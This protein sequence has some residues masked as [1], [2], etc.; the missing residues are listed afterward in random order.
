M[1]KR[2]IAVLLILCLCFLVIAGDRGKIRLPSPSMPTESSEPSTA[3]STEPPLTISLTH[4]E[5]TLEQAGATQ[6]LYSGDAPIRQVGF[7]SDDEAIATFAGGVVTA[8]AEGT[9]TVHASYQGTTV[10]CTVKCVF[11]TE[12]PQTQPPPTQP[13]ISAED[14]LPVLQPPESFEG[15]STFFSDAVFIGDSVSRMLGIYNTRVGL[16]AGATFISKGSYSVR[17]AVDNTM[18]LDFRGK[19]MKI[20]DA[21]NESGCKKVFLMLGM[22]DIGIYGVTKTMNRW[23]VLLDRLQKNCPD[24]EIYIQSATPI[25]TGSE[26]GALN[27]ERMDAYNASL[28]EFAENNGCTF[29]DVASYLKDHTGGLAAKYTSDRYVHLSNPGSQVWIDVLKAFFGC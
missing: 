27:N 10:S 12:P 21:I 8:V 19:A 5:L 24:V 29:I 23:K 20:E 17:H 3:P 28:K 4:S 1:L 26:I 9:T 2:I 11:P 16:V 14:R 18:L 7:S 25:Y 22:N 13:P 15:P 6:A